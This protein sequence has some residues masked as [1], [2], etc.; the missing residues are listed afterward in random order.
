[1]NKLFL[2]GCL[3]IL[4]FNSAAQDTT[5]PNQDISPFSS[6]E[7][8][9]ILQYNSGV[10]SKKIM[11]SFAEIDKKFVENPSNES[12]EKKLDAIKKA[13]DINLS[14]IKTY[15]AFCKN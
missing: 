5:L 2:I 13:S 12:I 8:C 15:E 14:L 4:A 7:D 1:M 3:S 9:L 11:A 6:P 10:I